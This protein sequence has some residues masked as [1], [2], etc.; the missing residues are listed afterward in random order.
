MELTEFSFWET[1]V[2]L[3]EIVSFGTMGLVSLLMDIIPPSMVISSDSIKKAGKAVGKTFKSITP[4]Q[5][6][7]IGRTVGAV[8][9]NKY[10]VYDNAAIDAAADDMIVHALIESRPVA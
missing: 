4:E 8:I 5:E 10:R 7:Y 1:T 9:I 3:L 6:Y 2:L